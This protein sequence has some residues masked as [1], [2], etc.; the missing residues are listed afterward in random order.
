MLRNAM[1]G[2]TEPT[3]KIN[4]TFFSVYQRDF[5]EVGGRTHL[6]GRDQR[7]SQRFALFICQHST[8]QFGFFPD[9]NNPMRH[10][11]ARLSTYIPLLLKTYVMD[12]VVSRDVSKVLLEE[13]VHQ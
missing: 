4:R 1:K 8:V 3:R 11:R 5:S 13:T 7:L 10:R 2:S 9:V 6:V 12:K